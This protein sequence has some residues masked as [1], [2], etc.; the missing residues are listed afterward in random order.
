MFSRTGK[1]PALV[2]AYVRSALLVFQTIGRLVY[3]PLLLFI[4]LTVLIGQYTYRL[5]F[6]FIKLVFKT[7]KAL[8]VRLAARP[9][10]RIS[11]PKTKPKKFVKK[12]I[13]V[14][15]LKRLA[16][17]LFCLTVFLWGTLGFYDWILKDLPD[18]QSLLAQPALTTKL[19]DR[20]GRLLYKIY[21]DQNRTL[22]PLEK[23]PQSL[24]Q[25]TV[26]IEDKDF[27]QHRGF[28]FRG[29][30]RALEHNIVDD[31]VEGG[32]TITQQLIKNTLLTPEKTVQRK[33]KELILS[34]QTE[35]LFN[36]QQI[37]EM[38]FNTVAYGGT[39]YGVEEASQTYFSKSVDQLTPAESAL[40]A[41]LPSAPS[42]YSPFGAHPEL[43][44]V[45]QHEVLRRMVE[46]GYLTTAEADQIKAEKIRLAAMQ[47][48]ILAPHFV[49][50][51]K[52]WLADQ[53][54]LNRVEKGGL[55]VVSSLD[56]DIQNVAETVVRE[57]LGKLQGMN[58]SNAAALVVDVKNGGLLAMVGSKDYYDKAI[59]G[60]VNVTLQLR[61]P[62][63]TIKVANYSYALAHGYTAASIISDTPISYQVA[64]QPTYHPVNYDGRYHGNVT[65][66]QA[67][68]NSYN[69]PAVKVLAS[70]G[71]AN[72]IQQAEQMGITTWDHPERYGLSLTLGGGDVKMIDL[73]QVYSVLA[74]RGQKVPIN[75]VL[76]V[77]DSTKKI[78]MDNPCYEGLAQQPDPQSAWAKESMTDSCPQE[79]AVDPAIAYILS[80]ILA[81][82]DSRTSAF[83]PNSLL[84]IPGQQVAVKTGTTNDKR[85]NWCIGYTSD[86]LVAVWVGNNDNQPM[87]GIASGIT[88]ATPIWNR[89]MT[90]VLKN[91]PPHAFTK[92]V[93][94]SAV[95]I[96]PY[97][98]YLGCSGCPNRT[99]YFVT[100]TEPKYS[101]QSEEVKRIQEEQTKQ[102]QNKILEGISD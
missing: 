94:V 46:D 101:C 40:L 89:I 19:Y 45:R 26:A 88:G 28:S 90:Q 15:W 70:Y 74:N 16:G 14:P 59:D 27:F 21:K 9:S 43:S 42:K 57:E 13:P 25:A 67:L 87:S 47:N 77:K 82:N 17:F 71:V 80:D 95:S 97:N 29:A 81:D 41:G 54:T 33:I 8:S 10:R 92:P 38:Y 58:V 53:V 102:N 98:G 4:K 76:A 63:S 68:A 3:L 65:L 20:Q 23:I 91:Q 35:L 99:E 44:V 50:Y 36:K 7:A 84:K 64:G 22:V 61:Q 49:M 1:W 30:L 18:P 96:C 24:I 12:P 83:G 52:D 34:F 55:T 32:S 85:D 75:P 66:R 60:N 93:N 78:I 11:T 48:N 86:Y 51:L 73:A 69:V 39:A 2:M 37:L 79:L 31:T 62:G 100:G 6:S 56:L 5:I 72:M